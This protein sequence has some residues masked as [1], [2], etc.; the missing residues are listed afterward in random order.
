MDVYNDIFYSMLWHLII[1]EYHYHYQG[2]RW[3]V[4]MY[5]MFMK[6]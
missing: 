4:D 3:L 2:W 6:F 5:I 1:P